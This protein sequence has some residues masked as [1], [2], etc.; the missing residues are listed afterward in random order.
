[1][2]LALSFLWELV[3]ETLSL[4]LGSIIR[5]WGLGEPGAMKGQCTTQMLKMKGV[6]T[7]S[8]EIEASPTTG[9]TSQYISLSQ[10][11]IFLG[12]LGFSI[13]YRYGNSYIL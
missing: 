10:L 7:R 5:M 8:Q 12:Q 13:T 11:E 3:E 1:M 9:H 2:K 4:S 6:G